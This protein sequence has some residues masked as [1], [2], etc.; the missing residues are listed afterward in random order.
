MTTFFIDLWQDLR[1]KRLWPVAVGL[2]AAIVAVPVILFKPASDAAPP[3]IAAAQKAGAAPTL[4]V[5]T[6]GTPVRPR[7]RASR[8]SGPTRRTRSSR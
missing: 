2:L 1:E 8:P 4:P 6:V 5:V 7:V 3:S